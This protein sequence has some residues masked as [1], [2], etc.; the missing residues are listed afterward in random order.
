MTTKP[1]A[2]AA[3]G[4][5]AEKGGLSPAEARVAAVWNAV[6]GAGATGAEANGADDE[7]FRLGGTRAQAAEMAHR[8]AEEFGSEFGAEEL[9]EP[10][11]VRSVASFLAQEALLR[12]R[13]LFES[14]DFD[15]ES[16]TDAMEALVAPGAPD[17]VPAIPRSSRSGQPMP[18]SFAQRRLWFLDQLDP[19]RAEYL[20]PMG[21]RISGPL[22]VQALRASLSELVSRHEVLRTRF[23]GD[24]DGDPG[25]V[26]DPPRPLPL[27]VHDLRS[28]AGP[29]AREEAAAALVET[30]GF[31]PMDLGTGPMVRALLIRLADEEHLLALTVHHIAFDGWSVGVLSRELSA[32]YGARTTGTAADLPEPPLQYADFA[33]WQREWFTGEVLAE[34]LDYWRARLTGTEPLELPTDRRRP[35]RRSGNGAM[36]TFRVPARTADGARRVSK[37]TGASLFM[38]LLA[39]FQTVLSRYSGQEDIA[40]G[41]PIAGRNRA[42]IEN[43]IGFFVNTLVMRTDLSGD[44]TFAEL[45]DRVKET[46]L[47]AYD[48]QDLPFER[49]VEE[50]APR[51]DLSRNPLFQTM[52]VLQNT[53]DSRSWDLPGLTVRQLDVSAQDSKFDFTFYTSEAADGAL[54]GTI[55][56]AT[57]L[58]DEAT[59]ERL[60][61]HFGTL[62]ESA[63]ATPDARLSELTMLTAAERRTILGEWNGADTDAPDTVT[64]PQLIEEQAARRPDATAVICGT[65]RLT[66]HRLDERAGWI[67]DRLRERGAG[68]GTLVAVCLD[69]GTDMV[70]ALLGIHRAGAAYL[71]LDPDYPTDRLAYMVEDSG[72]PLIVTQTTHTGRLPSGVPTL[73][74]DEDRPDTTPPGPETFAGPVVQAGPDDVAYVIYT[75]GSTGRPKGVQITHGALR[76]R[77]RETCRELGFTPEDRVLQFASIAFDSSVGQ[78]FAPLVSGA[79]LVLRDDT[80]DPG[81]LAAALREHRVTVAWLT[82]SAFGALAAD[83]DG[84]EALGPELRLVRLGGEALQR[85]QVRQWFRHCAVPLVNGYGPSEAAQEAT[86]ARIDGPVDRVP[87]GRPV[88]N[89]KVFVVDPHGRPVPV[90]VPGEMWIGCPGLARGYLNRPEL[91]DEKFTVVDVDGTPRRVYRTGDLARWMP[92]GRLEFVGRSD[93]Q[94]KLRGYRVEPGEIEAALLTHPTVNGA[95]VVLREDVPGVQRL[96]AYVVP[97]GPLDASALRAHLQRDLPDYMVPTAFVPLERIPLTPNG[98]T[99]R[100]A[101]PA[102]AS[103]RSGLDAAYTEPRTDTERTVTEVWSEVLGVDRIGVHDDFFA[104]GGHS[105]L[106]TQVASR[107]R[108]RLGADV[109][110]RTLFGAPTPALLAAAVT[111]LDGTGADRIPAAPRHDGPPPLSFAQ[112]RLWFLDQ[113]EPGRAEYLLPFAL[114]VHGP[115]DIDALNA[116]FTAVVARHEV[117]RTRFVTDATGSPAQLIDPPR[118]VRMLVRDL[119]RTG[120]AATRED[121]LA[122]VLGEDGLRPIDLGTGPM[123]RALLVRLADEEHVLAVTVHHIAFDGWCR[124]RPAARPRRSR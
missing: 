11:T 5:R 70:C 57:D 111:G 7:F 20:I 54:D 12:A 24:D 77:M 65:D 122:K 18:L 35:A 29:D 62:L 96:V 117:L 116:A 46:A 73:L 17:D 114:R 119:R 26:V 67:A 14:A 43:M 83:L 102:P 81:R 25:Q 58:F 33:V 64:V 59:M 75:S 80:W 72:A 90:G 10:L 27:A 44:P 6:L 41:T 47:G 107:L 92:D 22:D 48:H 110:V 13:R 66:Y 88:A 42:E 71:P 56:Y 100:R 31:R 121:A 68:P 97:V 99:D 118:P 52:F 82:P 28:V 108:R 98:K 101:L 120:D 106:A 95:T 84:P 49:L 74:L 8:I 30:G 124:S 89:A 3:L 16:A 50:L 23:V 79:G 61:G 87:I 112:Q 78:M 39:V 94:V 115:L 105:L 104:L 1:M 34:Q 85:E 40:V 60:A 21:L 113:L 32:L 109:P 63:C 123:L 55:V 86:T 19:G 2:A 15:A 53:P 45:L 76:A 9:P 51:R 4:Q 93:N 37:E 103:D 91:T 69:R 38:T 36:L